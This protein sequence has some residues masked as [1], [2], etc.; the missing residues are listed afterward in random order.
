V[1]ATGQFVSALLFGTPIAATSTA[2]GFLIATGT[3]A[4]LLTIT[5]DRSIGEPRLDK[6]TI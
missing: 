1:P 6:E 4:A 5:V 2:A 3:S